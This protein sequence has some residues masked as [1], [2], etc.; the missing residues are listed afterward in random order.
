MGEEKHLLNDVINFHWMVKH[1]E[2]LPVEYEADSGFFI[3]DLYYI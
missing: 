3:N 1:L 2:F